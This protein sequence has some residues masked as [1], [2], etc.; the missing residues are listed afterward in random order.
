MMQMLMSNLENI[1]TTLRGASTLDNTKKSAMFTKFDGDSAAL[2][3]MAHEVFE[4]NEE[5]FTDAAP[6]D[7][8]S[9]LQPIKKKES[10]LRRQTPYLTNAARVPIPQSGGGTPFSDATWFWGCCFD[11]LLAAAALFVLVINSTAVL[12]KQRRGTVFYFGRIDAAISTTAITLTSSPSRF[13][14]SV[15]LGLI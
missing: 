4:I 12:P 15:A 6:T 8:C 13:S 7:C 2:S 10:S 3:E 9:T 1:S 14:Y 5:N 11:A